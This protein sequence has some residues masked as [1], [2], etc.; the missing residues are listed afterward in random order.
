[1]GPGANEPL[2]DLL[3]RQS[4]E[5]LRWHWDGAYDFRIEGSR[6]VAE[7]ADGLGVITADGPGELADAVQKDYIARP[8][9]REPSGKGGER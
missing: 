4:L 2:S 6:W 7:R 1:M 9:P 8:V 3:A 5:A